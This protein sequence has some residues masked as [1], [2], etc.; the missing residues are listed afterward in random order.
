M[1]A[2]AE[3][4]ASI[5]A[6][7]ENLAKQAQQLAVAMKSD[8]WRPEELDEGLGIDRETP[9]GDELHVGDRVQVVGSDRYGDPT[10]IVKGPGPDL[11]DGKQRVHVALENGE[12]DEYTPSINRVHL[13]SADA[14]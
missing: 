7:L 14:E 4:V 2:Y 3:A 10:A 9:G 12:N 13:V 8:G 11:G 5:A 1:S 6:H